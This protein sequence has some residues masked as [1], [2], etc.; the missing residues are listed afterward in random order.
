MHKCAR[1]A[2]LVGSEVGTLEYWTNE[3]DGS[4]SEFRHI[5]SYDI[6]TRNNPSQKSLTFAKPAIVDYNTDGNLDL[7][8]GGKDGTIMVYKSFAPGEKNYSASIADLFGPSI[9]RYNASFTKRS[10]VLGAIAWTSLGFCFLGLIIAGAIG[11]YES[12]R[13]FVLCSEDSSAG[14]ECYCCL[15]ALGVLFASI[16]VICVT[17]NNPWPILVWYILIFFFCPVLAL[18]ASGGGAQSI[19]AILIFIGLLIVAIIISITNPIYNDK[20]ANFLYDGPLHVSKASPSCADFDGDGDVDCVVGFGNGHMACLKNT[21]NDKGDVTG[22]PTYEVS[23]HIDWSDYAPIS[24]FLYDVNSDGG[25]AVIFP[26]KFIFI[27]SLDIA[28][29]FFFPSPSLSNPHQATWTLLSGLGK[30]KSSTCYP[31]P[32]IRHFGQM[33]Q[34]MHFRTLVS[35]F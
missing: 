15:F 19:M 22:D 23:C 7:L 33:L 1:S 28:S 27:L 24:P 3:G 29:I 11:L 9:G 32:I 10:W 25:N 8:V 21:G 17:V 34:T 2:G 4:F 35:F 14:R 16:F 5:P 13:S 20:S 26:V 18:A 30:A 12:L 6:S 31:L